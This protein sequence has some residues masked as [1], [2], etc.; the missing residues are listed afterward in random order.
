MITKRLFILITLFLCYFYVN[1]DGWKE[2]LVRQGIQKYQQLE[3]LNN[4]NT[5]NGKA[6]RNE[7]VIELHENWIEERPDKVILNENYESLSLLLK[8]FNNN[9]KDGLRFYIIVVNNYLAHL[10]ETAELLPN[11]IANLNDYVKLPSKADQFNKFKEEIASIPEEIMSTMRQS[12]DERILY[13]YGRIKLYTLDSKY[14]LYRYDNLRLEGGRLGELA[15]EIKSKAKSGINVQGSSA[16]NIQ[17]VALNVINSVKIVIDGDGSGT[18]QVDCNKDLAQIITSTATIKEKEY[19]NV[20]KSL[21][22]L[23]DNPSES[24]KIKSS[25]YLLF[26]DAMDISSDDLFTSEILSDKLDL[27]SNSNYSEYKLFVV[28]KAVNFALPASD[29]PALAKAVYDQSTLAKQGKTI[30]MVIP[31]VKTTCVG[32]N[33]LG[34]SVSTGTGMIM[35]AVYGSSEVDL[36]AMNS[37]LSLTG[38]TWETA[39]NQAFKSIPKNYTAYDY[40]FLWNGDLLYDGIETYKN[41]T[42]YSE[43]TEVRILVDERFYQLQDAS[44][45]VSSCI[46]GTAQGI[47]GASYQNTEAQNSCWDNYDNIVSSLL[48]SRPDFRVVKKTNLVQGNLT[49]EV[50][51][52]F[53]QWYA[54][55]KVRGFTAYFSSPENEIFYGGRNPENIEDGLVLIDIASGVA[56]FVGADAIFDGLG[57]YYAYSNGE[58]L[59]A[60]FYATA[61]TVPFLSSAVRRGVMD[62]GEYVLKTMKGSYV[63]RPRN[64][65]GMNYILDVKDAFSQFTK[66]ALNV[67]S[68]NRAAKYKTETNFIEALEDGMLVDNNAIKSL[69]D[70][71]ELVDEFNVFYKDT[72]ADLKTFLD[73]YLPEV[74]KISKSNLLNISWANNIV[75]YKSSTDAIKFWNNTS[76][77]FKHLVDGDLYLKFDLQEG[78]LLFGNHKT[79]ELLGFY[80]GLKNVEVVREKGLDGILGKLKI[81]HGVAGSPSYVVANVSSGAKVI[82]NSDKTATIVGNYQVYPYNLKDGSGDMKN[83][84][85]ELLSDLKTQQFGGKKGGFNILNVS[86]E[87]VNGD[88]ENFWENFNKPWLEEAIKRGDDIW[89]AS[90]PMDF[91]LV[92][93]QMPSDIAAV[94][95]SEELATYLRTYSNEVAL[96]GFGKEIKLLSENGY[97]FDRSTGLFI[98]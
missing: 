61:A 73:N 96:S 9:R 15:N 49:P 10:D 6:Y 71:P 13:F 95:T 32:K 92:F 89:A 42:D 31:Y 77:E 41:V 74:G 67:K 56:S 43:L 50:A 27:L 55:R 22:S 97:V 1:A 53:A 7:Y 30:I 88:W 8:E 91:Q 65:L 2:E 39:F 81:Y 63:T 3:A 60:S 44:S 33:W 38:V 5:A 34:L 16:N 98:K 48:A 52:E 35:P 90:N 54:K 76:K 84:I 40:K 78:Y 36:Q 85:V 66:T 37:A 51:D 58:Y 12:F 79:G 19:N 23:I 25:R 80:E 45:T 14:K 87:S 93:R 75:G 86:D 24:Q 72:H 4:L 29:W 20:I 26:E 18:P 46:A 94:T 57:A 28:F 21:A 83:T 82:A 11:R 69:N 17:K 68:F 62:G 47:P 64:V 70:N 59:Q